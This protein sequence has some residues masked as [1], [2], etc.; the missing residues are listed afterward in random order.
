[1]HST[2]AHCNEKLHSFGKNIFDYPD[3]A[4]RLSARC[5]VILRVN[6]YSLYDQ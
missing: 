3:N 2:R 4:L 6:A 5:L 1:M